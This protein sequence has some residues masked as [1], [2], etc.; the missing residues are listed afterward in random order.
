[1]EVMKESFTHWQVWKHPSTT[2]GLSKDTIGQQNHLSVK[3]KVILSGKTTNY[4]YFYEIKAPY[5][6]RQKSQKDNEK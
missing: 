4:I 5:K 1:M 6:K 2:Q 3:L